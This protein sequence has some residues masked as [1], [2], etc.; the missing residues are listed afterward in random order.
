MDLKTN[1][2]LNRLDLSG[3]GNW[4]GVM[5]ES[6]DSSAAAWSDPTN[7]EKSDMADK[8]AVQLR[9]SIALGVGLAAVLLAL[10][11]FGSGPRAERN[12]MIVVFGCFGLG[13]GL[14]VCIPAE[15]AV[16]RWLSRRAERH[17]VEFEQSPFYAAYSAATRA[18]DSL[19]LEEARLECERILTDAVLCTTK[20]ATQSLRPEFASL[21]HGVSDLFS[22]FEEIEMQDGS[23]HGD[24][25][26]RRDL[27]KLDSA[28]DGL[29]RIGS[30]DCG[31]IALDPN[32][33]EIV[34]LDEDGKE[35]AESRA[36]SIHHAIVRA[37]RLSRIDIEDQPLREPGQD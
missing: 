17:A 30:F 29:I 13:V 25:F 9:M 18:V 21:P 22:R 26:S 33:G 32:R 31:E 7:P 11:L 19:S 12:R 14:I 1:L 20:V 34:Y 5:V 6:S 2:E 23:G 28:D 35:Q 24:R 16:D 3:G 27:A 36:A 10:V 8:N 15:R 37:A 4:H